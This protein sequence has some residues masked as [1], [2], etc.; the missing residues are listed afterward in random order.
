MKIKPLLI[1][2]RKYRYKNC[3]K[4]FK[5]TERKCAH[6]KKCKVQYNFK[7]KK[8]N[9]FEEVKQTQQMKRMNK[10]MKMKKIKKTKK[11]IKEIMKKQTS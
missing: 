7:I 3:R 1:Q 10:I 6:T 11:K 5:E 4:Y 2:K 9:K 8:F